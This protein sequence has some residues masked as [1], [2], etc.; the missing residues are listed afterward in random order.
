MKALQRFRESG[1]ARRCGDPTSHAS[2]NGSI[3][4]LAPVPVAYVRLFP[5]QMGELVRRLTE[6]SLP[7][8]AS[9]QCQSACAYMG[10][11]LCGLLRGLSRERVLD[12][13]WRGLRDVHQLFPL[14]P[15][16]LEVAKGS[17][18]RAT[19]VGSGYVVRSL[20]AALWAFHDATD[21]RAA[22]LRAVNLGD[23]ADTTGAV[24]GQLAGACFGE[25]GIPEHWGSGLAGRDE[26]D[27]VVE[28][29]V[30]DRQL[31]L[32]CETLLSQPRRFDVSRFVN[33]C[34]SESRWF[35]RVVVGLTS[36][37]AQEAL[38]GL[39]ASDDASVIDVKGSGAATP[40]SVEGSDR[41]VRRAHEGVGRAG[42]VLIKAGNGPGP[43]DADSVGKRAPG[44]VERRY[45]SL[46]MA[47]KTVAVAVR[48]IVKSCD[49]PESVDSL[50]EGGLAPRDVDRGDRALGATYK[51]VGRHTGIHVHSCQSAR[52]ID[53]KGL[54]DDAPGNAERSD[55]AIGRAHKAV[56]L[57]A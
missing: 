17:F 50:R 36:R 57:A 38:A 35:G 2:G 6:S 14:H 5:E 8:H 12:P 19:P 46:R 31:W 54:R 49:F 7:T 26:I 51:T 34:P 33:A 29:L 13:D 24:C 39:S 52:C 16:V 28:R 9:P 20:E 15:E 45:R 42:R 10:V 47:H 18:R 56:V 1:D 23:D 41:P 40:R 32:N 30:R 25:S 37:Q 3:M 43:I 48:V 55:R 27:A 53:A 4:R 22:V 44:N 11:V 21:F